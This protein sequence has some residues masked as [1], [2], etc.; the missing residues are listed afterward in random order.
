M[1]VPAGGLVVP[2]ARW[3]AAGEQSP[4]V[5]GTVSLRAGAAV[6]IDFRIQPRKFKFRP[7]AGQCPQ[8]KRQRAFNWLLPVT[9][10]S[11]VMAKL[12][13][14]SNFVTNLKAAQPPRTPACAPC[15]PRAGTRASSTA[16]PG[17]AHRRCSPPPMRIPPPR[18]RPSAAAPSR[19]PAP[20]HTYYTLRASNDST[21]ARL[22]FIVLGL[23][24]EPLH[25]HAS[26]DGQRS[27]RG[28]CGRLDRR[29]G[30]DARTRALQ[31]AC[32]S[33]A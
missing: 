29:V 21:R 2:R 23:G 14:A 4:R 15:S 17:I 18:T 24:D 9:Y 22:P 11:A 10:E 6:R 12:S 7:A 30:A 33:P 5:S 27:R 31:A 20:P 19:S 25:E 28:R 8:W 26:A 1:T 16:P 3:A 13:T 32:M